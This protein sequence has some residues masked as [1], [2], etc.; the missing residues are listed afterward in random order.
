MSVG[1]M[2]QWLEGRTKRD[3]TIVYENIIDEKSLQLGAYKAGKYSEERIR[4]TYRHNVQQH[5]NLIPKL[6]E[7]NIKSFRISSSLFPLFEFAGEIAKRDPVLL[8]D[9]DSLGRAFTENGIRVTTHP[10]QFTVISSDRD[11]VVQNSI[12]ELEYHAWVF[13]KMGLSQTPYNA[14]NIHGGKANRSE[15]LLE[16]VQALPYNV[17]SRLTFE[18]DEKCYNVKK[19]LQ[20]Y[21]K[22][23]IPI[24]FD[25][26]H[27]TFGSDD[28]DFDTA[29][30]ST[31]DT[32]NG[33][34]P[35]QH[36]SNTEPGKEN[37]SFNERRSHSNFIHSI[38]GAQLNALRDNTIDVDLEAKMK[39]L[40]LIKM[41]NDFNIEV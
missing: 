32:W 4:D 10:G 7:A 40:A 1:L 12:R 9:L 14:I 26:H 37:G 25:S 34:K 19:L 21:E 35:L 23:G 17:K 11:Q 6:I 15:R 13:D 39:N 41:R 16:S 3:G 31:L 36:L 8:G 38:G 33:V 27:F 2:C 29:Y 22:S 20:I 30:K 5:L 24:V 18:N 28:Y